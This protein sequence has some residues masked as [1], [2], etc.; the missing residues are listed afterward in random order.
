MEAARLPPDSGAD[1]T[2]KTNKGNTATFFVGKA[3]TEEENAQL[4]A[5]LA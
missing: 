3:P 1:R 4:R 5:L 2:L